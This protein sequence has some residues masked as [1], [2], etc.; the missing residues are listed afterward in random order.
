[1]TEKMQRDQS[2]TVRLNQFE[3]ELLKLVEEKPYS[4]IPALKRSRAVQYG[5][6][7]A[8]Y[9]RCGSHQVAQLRK[10]LGLSYDDMKGLYL[11]PEDSLRALE[12]KFMEVDGIVSS[13]K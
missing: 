2:L 8:A 13:E 10:R 5:I 12:E 7:L 6:L 11:D 9:A 4:T 1:M 3:L